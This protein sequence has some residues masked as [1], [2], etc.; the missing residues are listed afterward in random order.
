LGY[1]T[2]PKKRAKL[3]KEWTQIDKYLL[4]EIVRYLLLSFDHSQTLLHYV[5]K[6]KENYFDADKKIPMTTPEEED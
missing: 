2:H 5:I 4:G 3:I 1:S 6:N